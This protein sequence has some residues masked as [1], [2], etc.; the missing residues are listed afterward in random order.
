MTE[1]VKIVSIQTDGAINSLK[2]LQAE[3]DSLKAKLQQ[4]E[5]GTAEY[6]KTL[7]QLTATESRLNS[8]IE[9]LDATKAITSVADLK[10]HINDLR[11]S[12]VTLDA[13]TDEYQDAVNQLVASQTKLNEVMAVSR[14]AVSAQEGSYNAL[15]N[16]MGALKTAWRATTSEV[17]RAQLGERIMAVNDQL[18]ALDASIGNHQRN[19][20]NYEAAVNVLNTRFASQPHWI[21]WNLEQRH[22]TRRS[23]VQP[24]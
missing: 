2:A 21:T 16:E 10:K 22:I 8:V 15:V 13:G 3:A 24:R 19:V 20:G 17:Q 12:L 5:E 14:G 18:K 11:D 7:S 4:L 9:G 1:N 6:E 23:C